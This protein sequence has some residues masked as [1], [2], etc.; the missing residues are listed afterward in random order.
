MAEEKGQ[1]VKLARLT[2]AG[3]L[4]LALIVSYGFGGNYFRFRQWTQGVYSRITS[5]MACDTA[6]GGELSIEVEFGNPD[7]GFLTEI[8][9]MEFILKGPEGHFGYYR[10]VLPESIA[11][12]GNGNGMAELS[13][14]SYIPPEHWPN[15]Q[16]STSPEL[17]GG[18]V[19]RLHLPGRELPARVP[20]YSP[21]SLGDM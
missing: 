6:S 19:V 16:A 13:L 3:S 20:V 15:L 11:I 14:S 10:I 12:P 7:V 17:N 9:S 8:E 18:L 5:A 1:L 2:A 4:V 21:V